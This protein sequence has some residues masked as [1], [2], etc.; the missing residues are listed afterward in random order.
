ME[1]KMIRKEKRAEKSIEDSN[2]IK[3]TYQKLNDK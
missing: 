3:F 1:N 2:E